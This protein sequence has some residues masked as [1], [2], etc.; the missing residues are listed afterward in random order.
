MGASRRAAWLAAGLTVLLAGCGSFH[1]VVPSFLTPYRPDV[2]QGNIVTS[3]M[4]ENVHPGLTR[5]QVRFILGT[6]LLVSVFHQD[7]WD[8]VYYLR[9]NDGETQKRRLTVTFAS[10]KVDSVSHDN[11]PPEALADNLI[12]GRRNAPVRPAGAGASPGGPAPT[13]PPSG[14]PT[15]PGSGSSLP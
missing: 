1:D 8:Y 6:P 12:L 2:Q 15:H 7:R 3:E 4:A 5:D 10:S 13:Q 14:T 11:L 9:R